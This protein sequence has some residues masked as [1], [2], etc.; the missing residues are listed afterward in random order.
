[1]CNQKI[2][3]MAAGARLAREGWHTGDSSRG[4]KVD[5]IPPASLVARIVASLS[6]G[7]PT[8]EDAQDFDGSTVVD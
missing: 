6:I 8:R 2:Q 4:G 5:D 7:T 1:M 3:A